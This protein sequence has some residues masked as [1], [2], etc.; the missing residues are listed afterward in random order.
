MI[1]PCKDGHGAERIA[2]SSD[3]V[4]TQHIG[5]KHDTRKSASWV[6]SSMDGEV[7]WP[8]SLLKL[9]LFLLHL[10]FFLFLF[11]LL[12]FFFKWSLHIITITFIISYFSSCSWSSFLSSWL[13]TLSYYHLPCYWYWSCYFYCCCCF[14][15]AA[16]SKRTTPTRMTAGWPWH[17]PKLDQD[18]QPGYG[19][20]LVQP[21]SWTLYPCSFTLQMITE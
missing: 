1:Y 6:P 14:G 3:D 16:A 8:G 15:A 7:T 21:W 9:L 13:V 17:F 4:L 20:T 18:S 12:F 19:V 10:L 11:F 5:A 2:R